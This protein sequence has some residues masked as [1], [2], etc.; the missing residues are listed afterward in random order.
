MN[1]EKNQKLNSLIK[2]HSKEERDH[3]S[4]D[5]VFFDSSGHIFKRALDQFGKKVW[6]I[7]SNQNNAWGWYFVDSPY[8]DTCRTYGG[9]GRVVGSV[10]PN[11][12]KLHN[13]TIH[14]KYLSYFIN[15]R[16]QI[17]LFIYTLKD[18]LLAFVT[19]HQYPTWQNMC[20][21][22]YTE[23]EDQYDVSQPFHTFPQINPQSFEQ[24]FSWDMVDWTE[25]LSH[26]DWK[27]DEEYRQD[28]DTCWYTKKEFYEYYGSYVQWGF[29][30]PLNIH[31]RILLM[32]LI[33]KETNTETLNC[34]ID[35]LIDI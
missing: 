8:V 18:G 4:G 20:P 19:L 26:D 1:N 17:I 5:E 34:L 21:T 16:N 11:E 24:D 30:H 14:S 12:N 31:R 10:E 35:K 3:L 6:T 29:Q 9:S 2:R 15:E 23:W 28:F 13:Y 22:K 7:L 33:S 27:T 32:D 25:D